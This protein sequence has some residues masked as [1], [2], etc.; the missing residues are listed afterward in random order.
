MATAWHWAP[1]LLPAFSFPSAGCRL[2][3][4]PAGFLALREWPAEFFLM[5]LNL[6]MCS[7]SSNRLAVELCCAG[8]GYPVSRP[9]TNML[10]GVIEAARHLSA[11]LLAGLPGSPTKV[12][13]IDRLKITTSSLQP[14]SPRE[15]H[16]MLPG[17]Y[18]KYHLN[19]PCGQSPLLLP[20]MHQAACRVPIPPVQ[21]PSALE[22][23]DLPHLWFKCPLVPSTRGKT[24]CVSEGVCRGIQ[25]VLLVYFN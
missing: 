14:V 18:S 10:L 22:P 23:R 20:F 15:G 7:D 4:L 13:Q 21:C 24:Q 6:K 11:C 1:S 25:S 5:C 3:V 16:L 17:P 9:S 19:S 2:G 8:T 12:N